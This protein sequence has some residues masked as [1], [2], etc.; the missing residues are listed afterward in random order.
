M[1]QKSAEIQIFC[2]RSWRGFREDEFFF[3]STF[4][5]LYL[6]VATADFGFRKLETL[7][8][9]SF[10]KKSSAAGLKPTFRSFEGVV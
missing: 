2:R 7:S 5:A 8:F 9:T 6:T 4:S 1:R 10:S 3:V